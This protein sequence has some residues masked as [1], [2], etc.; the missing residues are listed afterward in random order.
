MEVSYFSSKKSP[1][2]LCANYV[3]MLKSYLGVMELGYKEGKIF[4]LSNPSVMWPRVVKFNLIGKY[5]KDSQ[6]E[7]H[8]R[9]MDSHLLGL[10][11]KTNPLVSRE[12]LL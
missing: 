1:Q 3:F 12:T 5:F 4:Q 11:G 7:G 9:Q 2:T 6:G 8:A 10:A